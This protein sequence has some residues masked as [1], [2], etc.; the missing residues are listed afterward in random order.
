VA[1]FEKGVEFLTS[2]REGDTQ[3]PHLNLISSQQTNAFLSFFLAKDLV[4]AVK[5]LDSLAYFYEEMYYFNDE[6][7][8]DKAIEARRRALSL[9]EE[10]KGYDNNSDPY[11]NNFDI[12]IK[13]NLAA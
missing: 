11:W 7:A 12:I 6:E 3:S 2:K 13:S 8:V 10:T 9:F 1:A 5:L 4:S